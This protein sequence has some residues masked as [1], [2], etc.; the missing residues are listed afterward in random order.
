MQRAC[1]RYSCTYV[2]SFGSKRFEVADEQKKS[3][4][5]SGSDGGEYGMLFRIVSQKLT[6]VSGP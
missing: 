3:G 2:L 5:I 6:D 4:E 1:L